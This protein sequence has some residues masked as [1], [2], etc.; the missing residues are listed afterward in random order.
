MFPTVLVDLAAMMSYCG[1]S[2]L[3]I[4]GYFS[5]PWGMDTQDK[6]T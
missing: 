1:P 5:R 6:G 4:D 2:G 3:T